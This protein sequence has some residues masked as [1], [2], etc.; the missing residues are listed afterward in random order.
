MKQSAMV[1]GATFA[2]RASTVALVK[3]MVVVG[4]EENLKELE[5]TGGAWIKL[6][7]CETQIKQNNR[8]TVVGRKVTNGQK[9][10]GQD[11]LMSGITH[12]TRWWAHV[13]LHNSCHL[14][15]HNQCSQLLYNNSCH[16]NILV[17]NVPTP[18]FQFGTSRRELIVI[19]LVVPT[20]SCQR[21]IVVGNIPTPIVQFDTSRRELI[22]RHGEFIQENGAAR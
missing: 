17:G 12:G 20:N 14:V 18:I 21:N 1:A 7:I 2:M 11:Q 3:R 6:G 16:Q 9:G 19:A 13:V 10:Y 5:E 15:L 22:V 8:P 4:R